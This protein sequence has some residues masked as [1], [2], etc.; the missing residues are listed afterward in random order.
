ME[1]DSKRIISGGLQYLLADT[2][3][4]LFKARHLSWR[5]RENVYHGLR[6]VI[7]QDCQALDHSTD[8]LAERV[9]DL[10]QGLAPSYS[11]LAKTS[12]IQE[13]QH[14]RSPTNMA[15]QI[16][17]DHDKVL[18]DIE[19]LLATLPL[20]DDEK[21]GDILVC[22]KDRHRKCRNSLADLVNA[23]DHGSA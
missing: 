14:V 9:L 19:T 5:L 1:L 21:T 8:R 6:A 11:K 15:K 10:G 20:S 17:W 3:V 12:S 2:I 4:L 22:L 18:A 13:E 23:T 16:I 7:R